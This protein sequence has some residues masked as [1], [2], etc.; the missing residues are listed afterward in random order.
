MVWLM[1]AV[2]LIV[3]TLHNPPSSVTPRIVLAALAVVGLV[4]W[5]AALLARDG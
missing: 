2:S 5:G 1:A 4:V 3:G